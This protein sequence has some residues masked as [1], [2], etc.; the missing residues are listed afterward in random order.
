VCESRSF[1]PLLSPPSSL[2]FLPPPPPTPVKHRVLCYMGGFVRWFLN[3][4]FD[5]CW[6]CFWPCVN[7]CGDDLYIMFFTILIMYVWSRSLTMF[8]MIVDQVVHDCWLCVWWLLTMCFDYCW[9]CV[10][11][12]VDNVFD[13]GWPCLL[14]MFD[15]IFQWFL[16][17]SVDDDCWPFFR[18]GWQWFYMHF[19]I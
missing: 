9:P 15:C 17:M 10:L 6:S 13:D 19:T 12:I 16:T 2:F 5:D 14:T 1:P 11:T 4:C 3:M 7:I 8:L 18:L